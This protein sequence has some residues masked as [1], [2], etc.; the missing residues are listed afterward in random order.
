[1]IDDKYLSSGEG[2][3]QTHTERDQLSYQLFMF[4]CA[5]W[6]NVVYMVGN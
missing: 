2:T 4:S 3:D 5:H 1:M 6:R